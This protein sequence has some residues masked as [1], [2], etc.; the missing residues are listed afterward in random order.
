MPVSAAMVFDMSAAASLPHPRPEPPTADPQVIRACL[1]AELTAEFDREWEL[2]LD[3][4]KQ[5]RDL[6]DLHSWLT[7]WRH[8]AYMEL[9]DPGSYDH[10]TAKA[11]QILRTGA[12]PDAVP[13]EDMRAL[14]A[15]RLGR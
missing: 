2:V 4:V 7:K 3:R 13:A 5:S 10:M 12:R 15:Q 1:P 11:D 14:I 8:T 6:D 9:R